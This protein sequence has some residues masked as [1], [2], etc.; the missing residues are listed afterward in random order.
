MLQM[1]NYSM[2]L[3][4]V[5]FNA[6]QIQLLVLSHFCDPRKREGNTDET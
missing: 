4:L 6:A 3:G 2:D 1:R 5:F